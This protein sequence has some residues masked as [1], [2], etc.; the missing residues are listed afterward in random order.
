M[1]VFLLYS[2]Q[3]ERN[4]GVLRQQGQKITCL[5]KPV[6][7]L[8]FRKACIFTGAM[9]QTQVRCERLPLASR[10]FSTGSPLIGADGMMLAGYTIAA[11]LTALCFPRVPTW[12]R[13]AA[14][15]RALCKH[16]RIG[17][18]S[19]QEADYSLRRILTMA[20]PLASSFKG[21]FP[22]ETYQ[23]IHRLMSLAGKPLL[24]V[25]EAVYSFTQNLPHGFSL[26]EF[27]KR[28][29]PAGNLIGHS[30]VDISGW[31]VH[32]CRAGSR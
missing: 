10:E 1:V 4:R 8:P 26:G 31:Y 20:F 30:S 21:C 27:D 12:N 13:F 24:A 16:I 6:K 25:R 17:I 18:R 23:G 7:R 14:R 9:P 11:C 29:A 15:R 3:T 28:M 5:E 32:A 22:S 2:S 19:K